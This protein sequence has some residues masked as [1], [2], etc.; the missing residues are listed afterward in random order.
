MG[1]TICPFFIT[2]KEEYDIFN[3]K[4]RERELY[5]QNEV[6]ECRVLLE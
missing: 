6:E 5:V 3:K 4:E 2:K 1:K